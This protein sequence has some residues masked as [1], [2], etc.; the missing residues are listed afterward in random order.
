MSKTMNINE[1]LNGKLKEI[2][3][4]LEEVFS[5]EGDCT[6][7]FEN[8]P[9]EL[10]RDR[11]CSLS[12]IG[13]IFE[14]ASYFDGY[15]APCEFIPDYFWD[16]FNNAIAAIRYIGDDSSKFNINEIFPNRFFSVKVLLKEIVEYNYDGLYYASKELKADSLIILAALYSLEEKIELRNEECSCNW[17]LLPFEAREELEELFKLVS[18]TLKS[19]KEFILEFLEHDYFID[20]FDVLYKWIDKELWKDQ[21]F[22]IEVLNIDIN[23]VEYIDDSLISNEEFVEKVVEETDLDIEDIKR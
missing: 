21:D 20:E 8:I 16:D 5:E 6:E 4:E 7:I 23:A 18:D 9:E 2:I 10:W 13:T 15:Y 17:N 14:N 22:V 3:N 1:E 19:N 11:Y 12:L